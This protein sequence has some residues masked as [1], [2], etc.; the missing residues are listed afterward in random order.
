MQNQDA[1]ADNGKAKLSLVPRQMLYGIARIRE[2]G[3]KKYPKGGSDNFKNVEVE[4]F[5]DALFRHLCLYLDDPKGVDEESGYPH[6]WHLCCNAAICCE[7][8]NLNEKDYPKKEVQYID[9][10]EIHV[11]SKEEK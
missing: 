6:I 5:R 8:E 2:Y 11:R 9:D 3:I 1:K 10:V 4:R 7:L